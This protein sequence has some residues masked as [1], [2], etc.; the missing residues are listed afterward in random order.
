MRVKCD[1]YKLHSK[2][3]KKKMTWKQKLLRVVNRGCLK[4]MNE[5]EN[6]TL[7]YTTSKVFGDIFSFPE[8]QR[9]NAK[10]FF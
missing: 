5:G 8:K 2:P 1:H 3:E 4:E 10:A 9:R 6:L 7:S